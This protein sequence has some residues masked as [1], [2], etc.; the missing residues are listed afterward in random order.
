MGQNFDRD[1]KKIRLKFLGWDWL[2]PPRG[3]AGTPLGGAAFL[4]GGARAPIPN[5][6]MKSN[7][8]SCKCV[9]PASDKDLVTDPKATKIRLK[10][11]RSA[12]KLLRSDIKLLRFDFSY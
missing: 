11:L 9:Q 5:Y 3:G 8:L 6:D 2:R 4:S 12:L 1:W 10:L 7:Y